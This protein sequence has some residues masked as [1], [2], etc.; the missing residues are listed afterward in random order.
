[1]SNDPWSEWQRLCRAGRMMSETLSAAL[2]VVGKRQKTIEI[3][4]ADPL[5]ADY[6]ELNRMV[7]EKTV[8]FGAASASL[9]R[10]W[11][12]MQRDWNAQAMDLSAMMLGRMPGPRK[13]QAMVARGQRLGSAAVASSVRAMT[14]IHGAAT[15]NQKR[16]ARDKS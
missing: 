6:A 2:A 4:M 9:S 12:A 5:G 15:A 13:A 11:W 10:D 8:A 14:P 3:A 16:L 1:M 7:S